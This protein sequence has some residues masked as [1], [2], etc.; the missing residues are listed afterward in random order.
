MPVLPFHMTRLDA[1]YI[2]RDSLHYAR[3]FASQ[4]VEQASV[5]ESFPKGKSYMATIGSFTGSKVTTF[6]S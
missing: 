1:V 4:I 5:L 6:K 2:E 3:I